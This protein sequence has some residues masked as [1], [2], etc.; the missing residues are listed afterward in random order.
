MRKVT[1]VAVLL[2]IAVMAVPSFAA[3]NPQKPGQW[4]ITME[5]EMPGMP[6]KVPPVST[7]VCLTEEDLQNPEKA[8]PNDPKSDCKVGDY[9]IDGKK[10]SWTVDCP[11]QKMKG[12]GEMTFSD[13]SYS[14][15]MNMDL[16][17]QQMK[18]K[19]SGKWLGACKK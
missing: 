5:T 3:D 9:K 2:A 8:V 12:S 17:G 18:T 16:D 19:Y 7:T 15:F 10:V 11:K 4:K 1:F 13:D 6:F 14:G